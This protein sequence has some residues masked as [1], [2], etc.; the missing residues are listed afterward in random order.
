M[1]RLVAYL[2]PDTLLDEIL[3]KPRYSII[4]QSLHARESS[5][6]TNGDGFGLG[7]YTP[8]INSEPGLFTSVF[9]AWNDQNLL[10]LTSKIISPCFFAHVR[11]ASSGGVS[12]YNCHPFIYQQWMLMHNGEISDFLAV[13][14]HIRHLLDDEIYN[15]IKGE[16]DSEHLFALFIQKAK[17]QDLSEMTTVVR[18]MRETLQQVNELVD[19]YSKEPNHSY[20]NICLS[21]GKRLIS[22]RYCNHPDDTPESL[23]YIKTESLQSNKHRRH[24]PTNTSFVLISSEKLNSFHKDWFDVPVNHFLLV[25]ENLQIGFESVTGR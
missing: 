11:A 21:D 20:F 17:G 6:P 16:T 7:W 22:C 8:T 24:K 25:D 15:W 1:C 9:P 10:H 12:T 14:R 3:V 19:T 2:G 23:H 13:K 5:I 4:M 18:I